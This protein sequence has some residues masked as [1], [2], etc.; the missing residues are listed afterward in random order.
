MPAALIPAIGAIAGAGGSAASAAGGKKASNRANDLA[1]QQLGLQ[2][3]QTG[4]GNAV[5]GNASNYWNALLH[6]GQAAVQATGP[7]ASQI[8]QAAQGTANS[9]RAF[10]PRGGEQNLALA[11]NQM[12]TGNN[13][14]RLYAGM[15]PMAAGALQGIGGAYLGSAGTPSPYAAASVYQ[16]Q[17]ANAQQGAS[18]FGS[19]LYN[20]L[21][22]LQNR[23]PG[24]NPALTAQ[25]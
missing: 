1:Q 4:L 13:I 3:Q 16:Q 17:L 22:K 6:G 21:N 9:I 20:S 15:Q 23:T 25:A 11:Q 8:G 5:L 7:I 10:S 24:E 19:L 2:K 14:A 18:G 12:Q